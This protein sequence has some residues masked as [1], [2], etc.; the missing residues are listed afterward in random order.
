MLSIIYRR[1]CTSVAGSFG[2]PE[3][4][5][6]TLLEGLDH[7]GGD[8]IG[9]GGADSGVERVCELKSDDKIYFCLRVCLIERLDMP[10]GDEA[11]E[12]CA[13]RAVDASVGPAEGLNTLAGDAAEAR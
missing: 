8:F 6:G 3:P 13:A 2:R 12:H 11:P 5:P 7:D 9:D 1:C 10:F 4:S